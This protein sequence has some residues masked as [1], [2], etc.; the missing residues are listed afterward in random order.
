MVFVWC[1]RM[2]CSLGN[3]NCGCL[4]M[5][6]KGNDRKFLEISSICSRTTRPVLCA[7]FSS[8]TFPIIRYRCVFMHSCVSEIYYLENI[9]S[10]TV[11]AHE[12]RQSWIHVEEKRII[13]FLL[14]S[15]TTNQVHRQFFFIYPRHDKHFWISDGTSPR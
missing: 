12:Q 1:A 5:S 3:N 13:K 4:G 6:R 14:D 7:M 11:L 15:Y 8:N 9:I 2:S 10:L